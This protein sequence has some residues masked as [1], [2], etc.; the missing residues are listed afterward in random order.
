VG[1][2]VVIGACGLSEDEYG[3]I[4]RLAR[5][6]RVGIVAAGNFSLLAALLLRFSAEA[7]RFADAWE[8]LDFA[9]STKPDAPSGTARELAER[10]GPRRRLLNVHTCA[11]TRP[12]GKRG[13]YGRALAA[14]VQLLALDGNYFRCRG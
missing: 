4:D 9:A 5:R 3:E 8:I 6:R 1:A 12:R 11:V 7:T 13:W 2:A 10:L 14:P